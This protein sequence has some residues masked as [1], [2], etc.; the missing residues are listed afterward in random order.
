M[1]LR[2]SL[3]N[4]RFPLAFLV[5]LPL[6][7]VT[8][9][10]QQWAYRGAMGPGDLS[11]HA[12]AYDSARDRIVLF[13]GS[14]GTTYSDDTWEWDGVEWRL[15]ATDGPS[16]RVSH[17]MTYDPAGGRVILFGGW[18][19]Q[20]GYLGDTWT[21]SGSVWTQLAVSGPDARAEGAMVYD[22]AHS[23]V[24][25][26]GGQGSTIFEDTWT[27]SGST[28][29][30][31]ATSG[32]GRRHQHA[33]AYDSHR[34]RVVLFG[35]LS[36]AG[37]TLGD[38]WEWN[39]GAWEHR[40]SEE[41][42]GPGRRGAGNHMAYDDARNRVVLFGGN[43]DRRLGDTWEW[44]GQS[45]HEVTRIGPR[46]RFEGCIVYHEARQRI[47]LVGGRSACESFDDLWEYGQTCRSD[48][49]DDGVTNSQDFFDFL[50][51]FFTGCP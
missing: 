33:L 41:Q 23:Q 31:V 44:D 22:S 1:K 10:G 29:A 18:S 51:A 15:V 8:A 37:A 30:R 46:A 2:K 34:E 48:F 17:R 21:W 49:N 27:L 3:A 42:H 25:L 20:T 38:T 14:D 50:S 40:A 35:G 9:Y 36:L 11:S 19:P 5:S 7:A 6:V 26:F 12:V 13:G 24:V 32:P 47:M 43:G 4:R 45:W 39:G 28:W 16:G